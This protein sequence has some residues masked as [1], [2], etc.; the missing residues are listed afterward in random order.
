MTSM[1]C[2]YCLHWWRGLWEKAPLLWCV[3]LW[4][5]WVHLFPRNVPEMLLHL[6][7]FTGIDEHELG[8]THGQIAVVC[9]W[10]I[11]P[12]GHK[13]NLGSLERRLYPG[14]DLGRAGSVFMLAEK[15]PKSWAATWFKLG[16]WPS[17]CLEE[18]LQSVQQP[19][20]L[21]RCH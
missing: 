18:T 15:L 9:K 21:N 7:W 16:L 19:L 2:R 6:D 1:F 20:A 13:S 12:R 4:G 14:T 11:N 3:K 17:V 10:E 8:H 5:G